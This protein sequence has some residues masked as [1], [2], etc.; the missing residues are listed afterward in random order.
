MKLK[1]MSDGFALYPETELER[2]FLLQHTD[3]V[4]QELTTMD[5][6]TGSIMIR[7]RMDYEKTKS[8]SDDAGGSRG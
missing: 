3:G 1:Y 6:D 4:H 7:L 5:K 8:S 2:I